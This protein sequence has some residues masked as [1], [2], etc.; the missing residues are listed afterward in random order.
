MP[1]WGAH[2][3]A[4][5][6]FKH[7]IEGWFG[8]LVQ[9]HILLLPHAS[10]RYPVCDNGERRPEFKWKL[11]ERFHFIIWIS[12]QF[13]NSP[14]SSLV[15]QVEPVLQEFSVVSFWIAEFSTEPCTSHAPWLSRPSVDTYP[16]RYRHRH[17]TGVQAP[18][19][20]ILRSH[21]WNDCTYGYTRIL[22]SCHLYLLKAKGCCKN[23]HI[24]KFCR[25]TVEARPTGYW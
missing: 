13:W 6:P 10:N 24:H 22:G 4:S 15:F 3:W 18:F 16:Y 20:E 23:G 7:P 1:D 17:V 25:C 12:S 9:Q 11:F 8:P 21:H 5:N 2:A 19:D 14:L